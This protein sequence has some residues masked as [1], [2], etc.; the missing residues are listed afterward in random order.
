VAD[1]VLLDMR[2]FQ[3]IRVE[4]RDGRHWITA[5]AGCQIKQLLEELTRQSAGTLPSLGL[6]T[7]QTI[8]GA[9]STGTHGSGNSSMSH[10]VDEVRVATYDT[11]SG[12]PVILTI[13]QG[14][15]LQAA[16]CSL[17][18]LGVIVSVGFWSRPQYFVEEHFQRYD[19]IESVLEVEA[20]YPLQ[21]FFLLPWLWRFVAQHRR[22]TLRPRSRWATLYRWYFFLLFDIGLHLLVLLAVR[23]LRSPR[24]VRFLFRQ[25]TPRM[26]VRNWKVV[27]ES[28]KMLV[29]EHELFRHI[30]CEMFVSRSRLPESIRLVVR[31]LKHFDGDPS[32][33]DED[34][35]KEMQKVGLASEID[36]YCG[37]Y[38]HH[39]PI[40]VRRVLPD[41]TLISMS[42]GGADPYYALSFISYARLW[43]RKGF[44]T[45][46]D[47]VSRVTGAMFNARPHWGKICPLTASEAARRYPELQKFREIVRRNDPGGAFRNDWINQTL[48]AESTE[49]RAQ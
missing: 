12:E 29:M 24:I 4:R 27:D 23:V 14:D 19:D 5:G 44:V 18:T 45:F 26:V 42:S 17:G 37:T 39:Y 7:E 15:E 10:F 16:R 25:L 36:D 41:D 47:V 8:A 31:L 3:E 28:S 46:A 1:D 21:Q 38:T 34:A 6:I 11:D 40:C 2:H 49:N 33:L 43:D 30:E 20:E 35:R 13:N 22:E 32:A 48:F 9:I